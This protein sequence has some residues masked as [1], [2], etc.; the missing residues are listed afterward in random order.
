MSKSWKAE[1]EGGWS[2]ELAVAVVTPV[3]WSHLCGGH[4][5]EEW[6]RPWILS[7]E[8]PSP[9]LVST[10]EFHEP[11]FLGLGSES[12]CDNQSPAEECGLN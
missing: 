12:L 1:W 10:P 4:T 3:R 9:T 11:Y 7:P 8:R 5:C 2:S 6:C